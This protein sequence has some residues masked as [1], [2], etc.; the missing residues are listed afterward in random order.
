MSENKKYTEQDLKEAY[1]EGFGDGVDFHNIPWK[2]PPESIAYAVSETREKEFGKCD[3][4]AEWQQKYRSLNCNQQDNVDWSWDCVFDDSG[5][6]YFCD[7]TE[8][9]DK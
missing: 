3:K 1:L 5:E 7:V 4:A 9:G 6:V 2:Y 8:I